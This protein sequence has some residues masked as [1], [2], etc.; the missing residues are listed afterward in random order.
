MMK[1]TTECLEAGIE[2]GLHLGAQVCIA[3]DGEVSESFAV[4][5]NQPEQPLSTDQAM[6]W[7]SSGKPLLPVAIARLVERGLLDFDDPLA[8][9]LPDF[10]QDGKEKMTIADMLTHRGGLRHADRIQGSSVDEIV[11]KI[12]ALS[13]EPRWQVGQTA[14]YHLGGTWLLLGSMLE[15]VTG[16][17]IESIYENELFRPLGIQGCG[18]AGGKTLSVFDTN[19]GQVRPHPAYGY[20]PEMVMARPGRNTWGPASGL[21]QFYLALRSV[22]LGQSDYLKPETVR[23]LTHRHREGALDK[24]FGHIAD[25]GYGFYLNSAQYESETKKISYGYG[26]YASEGTFGHSGAQSSSGYYDPEHDL[27]VVWITNGM[28]GELAHQQRVR[29]IQSAIYEDLNLT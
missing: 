24:T 29:S 16:D 2:K 8:E 19:Q 27:V 3:R 13:I 23:R 28:P 26:P 25:F 7:M 12:C 20:G 4:G 18:I 6:L 9:Y 22:L 14:G 1:K 21:A 5:E 11:E 17:S 15:K 10:S